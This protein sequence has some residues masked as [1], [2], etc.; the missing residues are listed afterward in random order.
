MRASAAHDTT[1]D[2]INRGL[3]MATMQVTKDEVMRCKRAVVVFAEIQK[4]VDN[5]KGVK[6][7]PLQLREDMQALV[8]VLRKLEQI[9]VDNPTK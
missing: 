2:K 3:A 1:A 8:G 9:A 6:Q 7:A 5:L 4:M